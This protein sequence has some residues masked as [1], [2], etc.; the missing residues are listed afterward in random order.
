MER[1]KTSHDYWKRALLRDALRIQEGVS[2]H[3][4]PCIERYNPRAMLFQEHNNTYTLVAGETVEAP[5]YRFLDEKDLL[6][7]FAERGLPLNGWN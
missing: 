6:Q 1:I 3:G 7:I 4:V 2:Q 5:M